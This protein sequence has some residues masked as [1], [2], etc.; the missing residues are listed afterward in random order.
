MFDGTSCCFIYLFY[1]EV[2]WERRINVPFI[3]LCWLKWRSPCNQNLLNALWMPGTDF[4]AWVQTWLGI[5]VGALGRPSLAGET[6]HLQ[7]AFAMMVCSVQ[8]I[9]V[10]QSYPTLCNPIDCS[11]PGLPVFH[12]LLEFVQTHG[13]RVGD[14][15]QPSHPLLS[16]SPPTFNLSQ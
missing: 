12:Q 9:S 6:G 14:A 15:I 2:V 8:F 4:C 10:A 5:S 3:F 11:M 7:I 1:F 13:H 16:S